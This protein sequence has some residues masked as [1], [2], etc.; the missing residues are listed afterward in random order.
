MK[1]D[2]IDK[3]FRVIYFQFAD[4]KKT[5]PLVMMVGPKYGFWSASTREVHNGIAKKLMGESHI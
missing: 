3:C 4:A 5:K 2:I 1:N